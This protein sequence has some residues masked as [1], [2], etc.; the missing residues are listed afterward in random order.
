MIEIHNLRRSFDGTTVLD[1]VSLRVAP[2]ELLALIGASGQGKSVLLKHVAGLMKPDRGRIVIDGHDLSKLSR[3]KLA[4][5]RSRFGFLF[6][7]GALFDSLTVFDNVAFPLREQK[8]LRREECRQRV[9]TELEHVGLEDSES[10]LPSQLSGGM[11]KRAALARALVAEPD[12]MFFDEPTTGLDPITK[13]SILWL[14]GACHR[15]LGFTGILVT[16]AVPEVFSIVQR[17]AMIHEGT[18]RYLGTP[19]DIMLSQDPVVQQFVLADVVGPVPNHRPS[20]RE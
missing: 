20:R 2:G 4:T 5:L 8:R 12:I 17:V 9:L 1:G 7:N 6:Q 14:I 16:H 10:K 3:R 13:N 18:I 15:R 11:V 19:E